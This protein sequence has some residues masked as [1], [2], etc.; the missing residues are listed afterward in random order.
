MDIEPESTKRLSAACALHC[1]RRIMGWPIKALAW[2]LV[3]AAIYVPVA[4]AVGHVSAQPASSSNVDALFAQLGKADAVVQG[5]GSARHLVYVFFD[6]NCFY[7]HL[8]WKALQPYVKAGLQVR[9][10]PVAY[11]QPSSVGRAAAIMQAPDRVAALHTN[12]TRYDA[13]KFDGGIT[14]L[15]QVPKALVAQLRKNTELM[16]A[17]GAPGTPLMVWKA[18]GEVRFKVGVPRLSELPAITGLPEQRVD[19]PELAEFR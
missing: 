16:R 6:A 7:C 5:A 8:T 1:C 12:E 11:Q 19:D 10:V 4:E 17:F 13:S 15:A 14:P 2:M 18:E 3:A 9:W